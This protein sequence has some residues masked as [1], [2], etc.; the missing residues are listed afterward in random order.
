MLKNDDFFTCVAIVNFCINI[1]NLQHSQEQKLQQEA[2]K[3]QLDTI[4]SKL[5]DLK[6]GGND[7]NR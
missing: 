5:D 3:K 7:E 2:L 1:N 6:R 4:E